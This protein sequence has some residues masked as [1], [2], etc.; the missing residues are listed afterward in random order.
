MC[1][2]QEDVLI[3]P[4]C[5]EAPKKKGA[6]LGRKVAEVSERRV[7]FSAEATAKTRV[8]SKIKSERESR[9]TW[10]QSIK[11]SRKGMKCKARRAKVRGGGLYLPTE[12]VF[13]LR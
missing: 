7:A 6:R 5:L 1:D 8:N 10:R 12:I 9:F 13:Q 3:I 2:I 4:T 11:D